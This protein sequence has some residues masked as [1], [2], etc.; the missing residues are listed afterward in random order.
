MSEASV[1]MH[2]RTWLQLL[3]VCSAVGWATTVMEFASVVV[4]LGG[5]M[6]KFEGQALGQA[7]GIVGLAGDVWESNG[8]GVGVAHCYLGS[9]TMDHDADDRDGGMCVCSSQIRPI[10]D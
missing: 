3:T 4:G 7:L 6:I 8:V 10:I 9:F 5:H 2:F 1:V